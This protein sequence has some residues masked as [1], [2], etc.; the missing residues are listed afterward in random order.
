MSLPELVNARLATRTDIDHVEGGILKTPTRPYTSFSGGVQTGTSQRYGGG[1]KRAAWTYSV[2]VVNNS[3]PG[4]RLLAE[5]IVTLLND[6]ERPDAYG[7]G[8]WSAFDYPGPLLNDDTIEGD[9]AYS[10]TL[11]FIARTEESR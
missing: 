3:E 9:W 11:Y 1:E 8:M 10:I 2:M 5:E 7:D 6:L 4:C